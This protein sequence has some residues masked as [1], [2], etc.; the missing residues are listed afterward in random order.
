ML[1]IFNK[2]I[3]QLI[4]TRSR[5]GLQHVIFIDYLQILFPYTVFFTVFTYA[6][7]KGVDQ[8]AHP[9]SLISTFDV[10]CLDSMICILDM[11]KVSSF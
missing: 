7:N 9:Q 10:R 11:S 3:N 6:N 1:L 2:L 8:P 4:M 5:F